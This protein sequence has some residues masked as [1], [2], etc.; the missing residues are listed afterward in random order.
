MAAITAGMCTGL[1]AIGYYRRNE[2]LGNAADSKIL[3]TFYDGGENN[4]FNWTRYV[5]VHK[6]CHN[7][8]EATGTA[9][10]E[11]GKVRR[12]LMGIH[13]PGLQSAVL[14]V[15]SSPALCGNFDAAVASITT[16]METTTKIPFSQVSLTTTQGEDP[17]DAMP[18][19]RGYQQ[20]QAGGQCRCGHP[21][22][23]GRGRGQGC[24][25]GSQ[26]RG[27]QWTEPITT[28]WVSGS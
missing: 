18:S 11:D 3:N 8:P 12:L 17:P 24:E 6:E 25:D 28:R 27:E 9:M 16:V 20:G 4:R 26:G 14:S 21:G 15:R 19:G 5:S 23:C 22:R 1:R 13:K 10:P 2:A 7:D